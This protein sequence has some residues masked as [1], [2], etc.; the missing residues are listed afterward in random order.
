MKN[1]KIK[2]EIKEKEEEDLTGPIDELNTEEKTIVDLI[3]N[4]Q[5][6]AKKKDLF[7]DLMGD[8]DDTVVMAPIDEA[9][10]QVLAAVTKELDK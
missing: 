3:Q 9:I 7:E 5:T 2:E 4:I 8:D 1:I 10:E 6:H